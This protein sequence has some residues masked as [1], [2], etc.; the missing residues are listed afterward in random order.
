M[1]MTHSFDEAWEEVGCILC[2]E[3]TTTRMVWPDLQRGHIVRC[4]QCGLAFRNPRLRE[5][6]QARHFEEEWTE[7]LPVFY[8]EDYRTKNLRSIAD[9]I[10]YRH[11]ASGAILDIGCSYGA[12]LSQF[13]ETWRRVGVEPSSRACQIARK[14]LPGAE[15]LQ[16]VLG[17]VSLP[18]KAFEVITLVDV[19]YYLPQ[20]LRDL[21][22]LTDLLKAGGVILIE[23]P[24]FSNRGKVYRL[25]RH[26]FDNTWM[27]FYTPNTLAK[28]FSKAGMEVRARFDLPGHQ[29]GARSKVRQTISWLEFFLSRALVKMSG[30]KLDLVPHFVLTGRR[31]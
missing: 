17:S 12:L 1:E 27:Y 25:M 5:E 30:G 31:I 19:I 6:D 21:S 28:L 2:G 8:L 3:H 13:P 16:G 4:S 22:R 18:E 10:L 26:P 20:P 7:A 11:P 29:V 23:S 15:I 14:R 9:W 24:N